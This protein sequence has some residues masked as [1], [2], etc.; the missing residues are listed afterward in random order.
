M[1]QGVLFQTFMDKNQ[2]SFSFKMTKPGDVYEMKVHLVLVDS[3]RPSIVKAEQTFYKNRVCTSV[4]GKMLDLFGLAPY[5]MFQPPVFF[6]KMHGHPQSGHGF[7]RLG[8]YK[9]YKNVTWNLQFIK[10]KDIR[11]MG[12]HSGVMFSKFPQGYLTNLIKHQ[13]PQL[14]PPSLPTY[15]YHIPPSLRVLN[16]ISLQQFPW[17][18]TISL[19]Q[20]ICEFVGGSKAPP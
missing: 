11:F 10:E 3:G 15:I 5:I 12:D 16:H 7:C 6:D 19:A 17:K 18:V 8:T 20:V 4:L 13:V 1:I 9:A 2:D 14:S